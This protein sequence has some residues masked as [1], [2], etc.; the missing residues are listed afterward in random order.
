MKSNRSAATFCPHEPSSAK[1]I[2]AF[3]YLDGLGLYLG[4]CKLLN[5]GNSRFF[6]ILPYHHETQGS[7][8]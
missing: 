6:K 5:S 2:D 8:K 7:T 3:I 4:A 1:L